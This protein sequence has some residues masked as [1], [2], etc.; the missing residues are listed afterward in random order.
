MISPSSNERVISGLPV[1]LDVMGLT[2][3]C[4]VLYKLP[5]SSISIIKEIS[6]GRY[7]NYNN[8]LQNIKYR[9]QTRYSN[10]INTVNIEE[11]KARDNYKVERNQYYL[12]NV[13][14]NNNA[15]QDDT[16]NNAYKVTFKIND[17]SIRMQIIWILADLCADENIGGRRKFEK[18]NRRTLANIGSVLYNPNA[19][20][21][22]DIHDQELPNDNLN[23]NQIKINNNQINDISVSYTKSNL[24]F[25]SNNFIP[26]TN[27]FKNDLDVST[28]AKQQ[29]NH[30][31]SRYYLF[32]SQMCRRKDILS[33]IDLEQIISVCQRNPEDLELFQSIHKG[34]SIALTECQNQFQDR[35]WNCTLFQANQPKLG[36]LFPRQ[37]I[38]RIV[39]RA[40]P[41]S[42]PHFST[43]DTLINKKDYNMNDEEEIKNI[44]KKQVKNLG[45]LLNSGTREAAFVHAISSAGLAYSITRACSQGKLSRCGCD[46]SMPENVPN[47]F[48]WA[49]CSD[50]TAFGLAF[51]QNFI[52]TR[53]ELNFKRK[54]RNYYNK[55]KAVELAVHT[56]CKC[57]GASGSCELKTC[58]R[59]LPSSFTTIGKV[60]K[61]KFDGATE[62]KLKFEG[63]PHDRQER[64]EITESGRKTLVP[65]KIG[66][67]P[68]TKLDLVYVKP[69]PDFC[70][71]KPKLGYTFG[72]KG[73]KCDS[74]STKLDGCDLM[75]CGRGHTT[76]I[77]EKINKMCRCKFK[78]CCYVTCS[79]CN[80]TLYE[81]YC[82]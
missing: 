60:L 45:K 18:F 21:N 43:Y 12:F 44:V 78:W 10:K 71:P 51:A 59:A 30:R 5:S 19:I 3:I 64:L 48:F 82:L 13:N 23:L 65:S 69:S 56:Y 81:D 33:K 54:K 39:E 68:Q 15:D 28:Y 75:C 22:L 58:W 17:I 32:D 7:N 74:R 76:R 8:R 66:I 11:I 27:Q 80:E 79:Q 77:T 35:R 49:G 62:V 14:V 9:N 2:C 31:F 36:S 34:A 53:E 63:K 72:T 1:I 50:N 4:Y 42:S 38:S 29:L 20:E 26:N 6:K 70:D 37:T 24:K 16:A 25:L 41:V 73:R 46:M 61:V 52:E 57:H 67:K 55:L 40:E 47:K